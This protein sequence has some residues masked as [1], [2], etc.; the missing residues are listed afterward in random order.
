MVKIGVD[1]D[2]V[3]ALET[4]KRESHKM[5]EFYSSCIPLLRFSEEEN[6]TI[7]TGRKITFKDVTIQ[8]LKEYRIKYSKI[9]FNPNVG[10]RKTSEILVNHKTNAIK[11]ESITLFIE[12]T[13]KYAFKIKESVP[14]CEILLFYN[15]KFYLI[16]L[17]NSK[18]ISNMINREVKII[19]NRPKIAIKN[20]DSD[21]EI[22]LLY[23]DNYYTIDPIKIDSLIF[24]K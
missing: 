12:D 2:G 6:I 23:N 19:N 17:L 3:I 1:L 22:L 14:E 11:E 15:E 8:W 24:L 9:I 18:T 10:M 5:N 13:P 20:V 21:I 7:I 4:M 16:N